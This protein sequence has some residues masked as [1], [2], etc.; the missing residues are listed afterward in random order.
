MMLT[1]LLCSRQECN[2]SQRVA[3]P[4]FGA[5]HAR[6]ILFEKLMIKRCTPVRKPM[7]RPQRETALDRAPV[8][9]YSYTI[10][11]IMMRRSHESNYSRPQVSHE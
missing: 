10:Q 5:V 11:N 8:S 6:V 7:K 3:S 4:H 1:A 2:S 9:L